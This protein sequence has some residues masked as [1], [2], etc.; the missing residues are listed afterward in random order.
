MKKVLA[1]FLTLTLLLTGIPA[2]FAEEETVV[3]G[4]SSNASDENE[5][6]KMDAFRQFVEDWNAAGNTPKL[7]AAVT[8]AESSV[9]K[10]IADVELS[11]IHISIDAM[12]ADALVCDTLGKHVTT[13]Y[14]EGKKREWDA[15]RTHVSDWEIGKYLV[16][17]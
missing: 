12:E 3:I 10:Q 11:L 13:Q 2:A 16:T 8:V 17:Y 15:Y 6:S 5:I 4:Y 14:V 9:E 1:L 7:E